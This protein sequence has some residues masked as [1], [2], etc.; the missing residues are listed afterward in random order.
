MSRQRGRRRRRRRR[1]RGE[2]T[3]Q[4]VIRLVDGDKIEFFGFFRFY[5]SN[6]FRT[7][8]CVLHWKFP[9]VAATEYCGKKLKNSIRYLI[10]VFN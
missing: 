4:R 6:F 1:R 2:Q 5:S 3:H 10:K 7:S 8:F 9:R